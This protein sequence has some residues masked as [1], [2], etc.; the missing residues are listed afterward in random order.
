MKPAVCVS[1]RLSGE[2]C[3]VSYIDG[4]AAR[5]EETGGC[6]EIR[7]VADDGAARIIR[8]PDG[9]VTT[10]QSAILKRACSGNGV[11]R[12]G[13]FHLLRGPE[14]AL[15]FTPSSLFVLEPD[16]LFSVSDATH[17]E[18]C[19]RQ[20]LVSFYQAD[21]P[22]LPL[23]RGTLVHQ[24]FP[25]LWKGCTEAELEEAMTRMVGE[26]VLKIGL[27]G[28]SP[29]QVMA[30]SRPHL[31]RLKRWA[32]GMKKQSELVSETFRLSPGWGL[33]GRIDAVWERDGVGPVILGELKTGRSRGRSAAREESSSG[34]AELGHIFQLVS[35]AAM[36]MARGE[37]RA[38]PLHACLLYSGNPEVAGRLDILRKVELTVARLRDTVDIRNRLVLLEMGEAPGFKDRPNA[39]NR[40]RCNSDCEAVARLS[41]HEDTRPLAG[42]EWNRAEAALLEEADAVCFRHYEGCVR[43]ELN[44]VRDE[45]ARLWKTTPE[46]RVAEGR[47]LR[48]NGEGRT[49]DVE[50]GEGRRTVWRYAVEGG[51]HSEFRVGDSVLLSDERGPAC[52]RAALGSVV[53]A[54][55]D[56][57]SLAWETEPGLVPVW[58]DGYPD[59]KL[60]RRQV[61]SLFRFLKRASSLKEVLIRGARPPAFD[62]A[63]PLMNEL[64]CPA[65]VKRLAANEG[66]AAAVKRALQT[67]DVMLVAGPPGSGKTTL[68]G[69]MVEAMVKQPEEPRVLLVAA[70]NRALDQALERVASLE[71]AGY[72]VVRLGGESVVTERVRPLT[73]A[74]RLK[75][76]GTVEETAAAV[77]EI[78]GQARVVGVTASTLAGGAMDPVLGEFEW[79]VVDE[80]SQM[81]VPLGLGAASYGKRL[82]L[83]GDDRQLPP[84]VRGE[85]IA[86]G[87]W[88]GLE[89]SLF[90]LVKARLAG[91]PEVMVELEHQFRMSEAVGAAPAAVW[92][93][94]RL[95]P[96]SEDVAGRT[97]AGLT[98]WENH[99][100][101]AVLDPARPVLMV[102]IRG[103]ERPRVHEG[104]AAWVA[105]FVEALER[106]GVEA[107]APEEGKGIS[108]AVISPYRAQVARIRT[109]LGLRFPERRA[110]WRACV[111][112]VDR[113]QGG[114]ADVVVVS[115]CPP[116]GESDHLANPRRLNVALTRARSKIILLGDVDRLEKMPV[117]CRLFEEYEKRFPNSWRIEGGSGPKPD[118]GYGRVITGP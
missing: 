71:T 43:A 87:E 95:R 18:Y 67:R 48:L 33:K 68:I 107:T 2:S 29:A 13:F 66:Q 62:Q 9:T 23:I 44:A 69:V 37:I 25:R 105:D 97:L 15:V 3:D 93:G 19:D 34:E 4:T 6:L 74:A 55:P 27:A 96:G 40:C 41:G 17:F 31:A 30:D 61:P 26:Q 75:G 98:E 53:E 36:L 85:R 86:A 46:A 103:S 8:L 47:A 101:A 21:S 90:E 58:V 59:E 49:A 12:I 79:V 45:L 22:S 113:F 102:H 76:L 20:R 5:L 77:G 24:L 35:Y 106:C 52:G 50:T 82:V 94:G 16:W 70:T 111:D 60:T 92:Y 11:V 42:A 84:V 118:H 108:L 112:T 7:L 78:I 83:I 116:A 32:D 115:L 28:L 117:F 99:G 38:D 80:A 72:P 88:P 63:E 39:C 109:V 91:F 51:N 81:T 100:W 14:E 110:R 104:E 1:C 64:L 89:V 65:S 54:G 57:L 114:E 10:W 73:I 56:E